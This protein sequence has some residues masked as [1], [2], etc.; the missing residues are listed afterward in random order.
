MT[1]NHT[2]CI[3]IKENH[4]PA[5]LQSQKKYIRKLKRSTINYMNYTIMHLF[6]MFFQAL[7]RIWSQV[8]KYQPHACSAGV[9]SREHST[10]S[11]H[12]T[13]L[14]LFVFFHPVHLAFLVCTRFFITL[15]NR[16]IASD[17]CSN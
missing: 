13:T 11:R 10:F 1:D 8:L 16:E 3:C 2:K 17:T 14:P 7:H 15:L 5:P 12:A 9:P 6:C 4:S